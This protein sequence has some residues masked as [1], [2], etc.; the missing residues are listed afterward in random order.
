MKKTVLVVLTVVVLVAVTLVAD[1]AWLKGS[2]SAAA[3]T[4]SQSA[5][6]EVT[7]KDLDGNAVT[8]AQYKGKV[9]LVNFWATWCSPCRIEMPWMIEFQQKYGARGFTVLGIAMDD[10][11]KSAVEP[12]VKKE[13]YDVDG[14]QMSIIYPI[15]LGNDAV[16]EKFGIFGLPTSVLIS[17]DG[18]KV[19]TIVGLVNH[20][21]LVK[22]IEGLL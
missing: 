21:V 22:E 11:G 7:L 16:A 14:K 17:R 2:K 6:P 15:L 4:V 20:D 8:L 3:K 12:F 10:E 18:K 1:R 19:K 9:V 13:R 5:A